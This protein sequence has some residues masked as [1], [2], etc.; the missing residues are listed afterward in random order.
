MSDT[1]LQNE[2]PNEEVEAEAAADTEP[3]EAEEVPSATDE[4]VDD[5]ADEAEIHVAEDVSKAE[6]KKAKAKPA[7]KATPAQAS[8]QAVDALVTTITSMAESVQT[9]SNTVDSLSAKVATPPAPVV[10]ETKPEEPAVDVVEDDVKPDTVRTVALSSFGTLASF[11]GVGLV[12]AAAM[13]ESFDTA[14]I[15]MGVV[16]VVLYAVNGLAIDRDKSVE[17]LSEKGLQ[18][19]MTI[20]A[21]L[22]IGLLVGGIQHFSD[23]PH[24]AAY[25]LPIGA[26]LF[27]VATAWKMRDR[28][29]NEHL[30]WMAGVG[31]WVCLFLGVGLNQV[32]GNIDPKPVSNTAEQKTTETNGHGDAAGAAHGEAASHEQP[33]DAH[34]ATEASHGE[35]AGHGSTTT[36]AATHGDDHGIAVA[37]P[38]ATKDDGHG[39]D[40]GHGTTTTAVVTQAHSTP[41]AEDPHQSAINEAVTAGNAAAGEHH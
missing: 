24:R 6:P 33:A 38:H 35:D 1:S 12:A 2:E 40:A 32:A 26:A 9:L 36:T 16:G 27:V 5:A 22:G 11:V 23:D 37:D 30:V 13:R 20:L 3:V 28:L 8:A 17:G 25:L 18:A 15:L 19:L 7:K 34:G 29:A 10:V 39:A 14:G 4:N 31:V 21:V 41:K